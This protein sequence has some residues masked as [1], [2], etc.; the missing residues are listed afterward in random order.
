MP[1]PA[2]VIKSKSILSRRL[3]LRGFS[4]VEMM[5]ALVILSISILALSSITI[6][7]IREN[8]KN[9]LRDSA[10]QITKETIENILA[11]P[12]DSLD[13][14]TATRNVSLRGTSKDFEVEWAVTEKSG[15]LKEVSITV[16]TNFGGATI[17]NQAIVYKHSSL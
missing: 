5:I 11:E 9:H 13:D 17:S 7:A 3:D 16:E 15:S 8:T 4:L 6:T 2:N 10:V 14:G 12:F 1:E